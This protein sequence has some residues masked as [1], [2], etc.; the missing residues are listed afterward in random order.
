MSFRKLFLLLE[1]ARAFDEESAIT[2]WTMLRLASNLPGYSGCALT[3]SCFINDNDEAAPVG[4]SFLRRNCQATL[5]HVASS[6]WLWS[7][8]W[9]LTAFTEDAVWFN[10]GYSAL[11]KANRICTHLHAFDNDGG[12]H[13]S[14]MTG[15]PA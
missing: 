8:N 1:L 6:P 11:I 3:L 9:S 7:K 14:C 15:S 12:L 5:G 2:H 13:I 4:A 10:K